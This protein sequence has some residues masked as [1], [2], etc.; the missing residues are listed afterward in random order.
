MNTRLDGDWIR[1]HHLHFDAKLS[2]NREKIGETLALM[3]AS[4]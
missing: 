2:A 1:H 4:S 3:R